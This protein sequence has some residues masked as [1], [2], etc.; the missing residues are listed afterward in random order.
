MFCTYDEEIELPGAPKC[1]C[2]GEFKFTEYFD[3][4]TNKTKAIVAKCQLCHK[5]ITTSHK[6]DVFYRIE[7]ANRYR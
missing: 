7:Q 3:S 6:K 2:G 4:R 1:K 5:T